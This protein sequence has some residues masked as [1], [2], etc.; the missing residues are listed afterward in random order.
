M[1]TDPSSAVLDKTSLS[2]NLETIK[3][4]SQYLSTN[5]FIDIFIIIQYLANAVMGGGDMGYRAGGH[6]FA[7]KKK[8][9]LPTTKFL[10]T[11]QN[12]K[13]NPKTM[14]LQL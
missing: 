6:A 4:L 14:K 9:N 11:D 5:A 8:L 3:Y 13:C 1:V 12:R 7:K 10:S 2:Y